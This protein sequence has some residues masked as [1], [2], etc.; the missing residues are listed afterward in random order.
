MEETLHSTIPIAVAD[1]PRE[2]EVRPDFHLPSAAAQ[3]WSYAGPSGKRVYLLHS[4][5]FETG[6]AVID[7]SIRLPT[8]INRLIEAN[9]EL[10]ALQRDADALRAQPAETERIPELV[11]KAAETARL[12]KRRQTDVEKEFRRLLA[13]IIRARIDYSLDPPVALPFDVDRDVPALPL[14]YRYQFLESCM[15]RW[16]ESAALDP[17]RA[18]ITGFLSRFGRILTRGLRETPADLATLLKLA[19]EPEIQTDLYQAY[20]DEVEAD[21]RAATPATR[22]S[23]DEDAKK[24]ES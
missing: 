14:H 3:Y 17:Y 7:A 13:S 18:L 16:T 11:E 8:L 21:R 1:I 19:A 4:F 2:D 10:G 20:L 15:A 6:Q 22:V 5:D 24:N 9:R 23:P 12:A